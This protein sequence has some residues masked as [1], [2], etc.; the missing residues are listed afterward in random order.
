[1]IANSES[2]KEYS[3]GLMILLFSIK[4][5][6]LKETEKVAVRQVESVRHQRRLQRYRWA[7]LPKSTFSPFLLE[8][9]CY[10]GMHSFCIQESCLC[11]CVP[12]CNTLKIKKKCF[13]CL[14][15]GMMLMILSFVASSTEHWQWCRPMEKKNKENDYADIMHT[16]FLNAEIGTATYELYVYKPWLFYYY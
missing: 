1:M 3:E 5:G 2:I 15:V 8:A 6:S 7:Q 4:K 16:W 14:K 9:L 12:N 13:K 11:I 10:S